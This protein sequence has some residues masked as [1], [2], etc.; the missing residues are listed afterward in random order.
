[1]MHTSKNSGIQIKCY[2]KVVCRYGE[3]DND[4]KL[5]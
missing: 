1:M 2:A 3:L 4:E 5:G